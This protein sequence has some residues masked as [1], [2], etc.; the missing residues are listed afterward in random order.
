MSAAVVA[1]RRC[2]PLQDTDRWSRFHTALGYHDPTIQNSSTPRRSRLFSVAHLVTSYAS[3]LTV[4][5]LRQ[6]A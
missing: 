5:R 1:V 2:G 3:R 4:A 6:F